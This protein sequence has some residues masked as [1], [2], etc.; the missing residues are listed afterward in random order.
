MI[1]ERGR[2]RLMGRIQR[3]CSDPD[4]FDWTTQFL[5]DRGLRGPAQRMMAILSASTAVIT[6]SSLLALDLPVMTGYVFV[7]LFTGFAA[8][9]T[10]FWLTRWPTRRQSALTMSAGI[11]L[12]SA[13][14]VVQPSSALAVLGCTATTVTGGYVAFFH[15]LRLLVFNFCVA[16]ATA[17]AACWRLGAETN[18]ATAFAAFGVIVFLNASVPLAIAGAT[19]ALGTYAMRSDVD[20]LTGL[21]NRRGF[22]DVLLR[23]LERDTPAGDDLVVAMVDLDGFKRLND[24]RGHAAGDRALR[25]VGELLVQAGPPGSAVCRAGGEEF[26]VAAIGSAETIEGDVHRLCEHIAEL[27]HQVTASVGISTA[28]LAQLPG[29]DGSPQIDQLIENADSAMYV[30]KR[31]GGNR[32]HRA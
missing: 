13:W 7:G 12:I 31:N 28:T 10:A 22:T 25:A 23:R 16:L 32:V 2:P 18:L 29:D 19:R 5:T 20:P 4:R 1:R 11:L 27:P 15:N 17:V 3:R 6:A 14:S 21:L 9:M 26:L 30:A 8:A 24:S